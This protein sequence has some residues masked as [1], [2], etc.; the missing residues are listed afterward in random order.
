MENEIYFDKRILDNIKNKIEYQ[1]WT[2]AEQ[3]G[4][5]DSDSEGSDPDSEIVPENAP[6]TVMAEKKSDQEK[7]KVVIEQLVRDMSDTM[8]QLQA[9]KNDDTDKNGK[10]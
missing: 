3:A 7:I 6:E 4:F 1:K 8:G 9:G 5:I 10:L 2:P